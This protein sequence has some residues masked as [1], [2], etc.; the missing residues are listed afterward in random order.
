MLVEEE[1]FCLVFVV[2]CKKRC[3]LF[4]PTLHVHSVYLYGLSINDISDL[5]E[6]LQLL[7]SV[8]MN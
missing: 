5:F 8:Y 1:L 7:H 6:L 3:G 2:S 4:I